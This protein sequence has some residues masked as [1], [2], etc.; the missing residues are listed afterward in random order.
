M[1]SY[2]N[3]FVVAIILQITFVSPIAEI[4]ADDGEVNYN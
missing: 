3:L 4:E 1:V 2:M